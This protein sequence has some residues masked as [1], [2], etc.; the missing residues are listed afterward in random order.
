MARD[1]RLI[2]SPISIAGMVLTTLSAVVFI[3]VLLGDLFGVHTNPYLG[4]VFFLLL[5]A[6]FVLGILLIPLGAWVERRR[7]A[8]GKPA[9]S[10]DWPRIDLNDPAHR[11]VAAIVV[12]LTMANIVIISL[13]AYKGVEYM[14]SVG[15]CGQAC[16]TPMRPELVAHQ[17]GPHAR[18]T[19]VAC[20]VAPGAGSFVRSKLAGTRRLL[21]I[22][23]G[24]YSRPIAA[25]TE[26]LIA[27]RDTCEQCHLPGRFR[28]DVTRRISEY[29]DSETNTESVTTLHLHV[30][31]TDRVSQTTGIHWHADPAT[32][33]E[34]IATDDQRQTIPWVRVTDGK[35]GV[36]EYTVET[37]PRDEVARGERR[38]ME[39]TD[40]HN[41][42]SH[43]IPATPERAVNAAISRGE[44]PA[45]LPF[46]RREAVK[47]LKASYPSQ[48][49]AIDAISRSL[50][51]FY[52]PQEAQSISAKGPEI[53]RAILA[54]QNIYRRSVFPEMKMTFG[55][56]ANNMGHIDAPGCFRCHD[57]EHVATDG[58][59]IGQDCET[60]HAIE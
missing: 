55:T 51:D 46:V 50:R 14:D 39:C 18:I 41:R 24:S 9:A 31:G 58:K 54:T 25:A 6:L 28:G 10:V 32:V 45:A 59:K 2:R 1:V 37:A 43:A 19:C 20:H 38:R 13:G 53:D 15:F 42:P 29:G 8:A 40:C 5:P 11:R 57:D 27:S 48:E 35:N 49:S 44:I 16:H 60:C 17:Q 52:T 30:G 47:A 26:D 34:Y 12:A 21:A 22:S 56:Y 4:I 33:V 7:R 23:R 36:R 3:V